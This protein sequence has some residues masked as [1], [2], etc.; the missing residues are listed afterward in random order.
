MIYLLW[1]TVW[2]Y[3]KI[4]KIEITYNPAIPLLVMYS[5]KLNTMSQRDI[6]TSMFIVALFT[7][8]KRWNHP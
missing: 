5:T 3:L 1:K 7:I 4:L 8:T 6:C 2:W